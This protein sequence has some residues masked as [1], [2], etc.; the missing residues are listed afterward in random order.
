M[1]RRLR[2]DSVVLGVLVDKICFIVAALTLAAAIGT[3][4]SLFGTAAL[5]LG[6]TATALGGF[7]AARHAAC[8]SVAHGLAVGAIAVVI[9]FGRFL[10]NRAWPLDLDPSHPLWWEILGWI[11]A[12]A[13]GAV[14]GRAAAAS[15]ELPVARDAF[16]DGPKWSIWSPILLGL[17]LVFALAEQL[18]RLVPA[19]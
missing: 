18:S 8:N 4:S 19:A 13:A 6:L 11:G 12:L 17:I 1:A 7:F 14:G 9:S 3:S 10:A 16:A 5:A 2:P 15:T